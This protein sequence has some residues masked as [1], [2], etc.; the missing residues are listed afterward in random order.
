V[1][2]RVTAEAMEIKLWW[3]PATPYPAA[4]VGCPQSVM[5]GGV[6]EW[7]GVCAWPGPL[8]GGIHSSSGT[9][10]VMQTSELHPVSHPAQGV[11][12]LAGSIHS[13]SRT[14][15]LPRHLCTFELERAVQRSGALLQQRPRVTLKYRMCCHQV[16]HVQRGGALMQ[17]ST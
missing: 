5:A 3:L 1:L 4:R 15:Q 8:I 6:C 14:Q 2:R 12:H 9:Q 17:C 7:P 13:C 16:L 11:A 10:P